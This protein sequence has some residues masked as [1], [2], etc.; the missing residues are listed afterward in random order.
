MSLS[1]GRTDMVD[2]RPQMHL[3]DIAMAIA[4]EAYS[5]KIDKAGRPYI[6]HPLRLMA[7]FTDDHDKVVALLHD[8]IEDSHFTAE[9]LLRRGIPGLDVEVI[10]TLSRREGE[11]YIDFIKRICLNPKAIPIKKADIEDNLNVLRLQVLSKEDLNR[12]AKYHKAWN[13]LNDHP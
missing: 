2:I 9:D 5:G 13:L 8:V 11:S 3:I 12:V 4:V 1:R 7:G 10:E 6:L